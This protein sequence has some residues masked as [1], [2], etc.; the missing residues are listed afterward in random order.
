MKGTSDVPGLGLVLKTEFALDIYVESGL[1]TALKADEDAGWDT[2]G[3]T[4][5]DIT[6]LRAGED[7]NDPTP[8]AKPCGSGAPEYGCVRVAPHGSVDSLGAVAGSA[9]LIVGAS[10]LRR[11]RRA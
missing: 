2:D 5:P 9:V 4:I 6:E 7:P 8:G 10:R 1:E 11:R 3:D